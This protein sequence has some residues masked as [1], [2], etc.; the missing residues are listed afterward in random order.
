MLFIAY[1]IENN[2][3]RDLKVRIVLECIAI[4]SMECSYY[5][6]MTRNIRRELKTSV[7]SANHVVTCKHNV[8]RDKEEM[9]YTTVYYS[10][11]RDQARPRLGL[12]THHR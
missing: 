1:L 12:S 6:R 10:V 3:G 2:I 9:M 11:G 8:I 5:P 4:P 7:V